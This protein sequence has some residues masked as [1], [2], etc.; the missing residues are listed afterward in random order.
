M[1]TYYILCELYKVYLS[2]S[3]SSVVALAHNLMGR[4][5]FARISMF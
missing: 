4:D 2:T 3:T 5:V 1:S